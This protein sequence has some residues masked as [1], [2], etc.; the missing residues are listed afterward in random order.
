MSFLKIGAA[1]DKRLSELADLPPVSWEN[2]I[3]SPTIGELYL[4]ATNLT[5]DSAAES[6]QDLN[7]GVYQIDVFTESGTGKYENETMA[8][9]L[10]D[11]F[12]PLTELI[13]DGVTVVIKT[14][15]KSPALTNDGWY[16]IPVN[17]TYYS[18]TDRR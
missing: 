4:R 16:Q 14:V 2:E 15:D 3:H 7:V 10:A 5:G 8:D 18:F 9:K 12:K 11:W 6:E 13:Y 17:I 1:L